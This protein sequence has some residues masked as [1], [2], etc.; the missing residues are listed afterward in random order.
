[1]DPDRT[2]ATAPPQKP[3]WTHAAPVTAAGEI[4]MT[5]MLIY[6]LML[7]RWAGWMGVLPHCHGI[8]PDTPP[9]KLVPAI[10]GS[11]KHVGE[12]PGLCISAPDPMNDGKLWFILTAMMTCA[13]AM[14]RLPS[15]YPG[16]GCQ[17]D[18]MQRP[19]RSGRDALTGAGRPA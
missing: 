6:L 8:T 19:A 11:E 12:N 2:P 7:Q 4:E 13:Q 18:C 3:R 9:K 1:M 5:C 16:W 17:V 10:G 15:I 14:I